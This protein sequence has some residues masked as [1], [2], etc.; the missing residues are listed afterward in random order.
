MKTLNHSPRARRTEATRR[1]QLLAAFDRSGL[2]AAFA[3]QHQ[4]NYTS[5]CGWRARRATAK[6]PPAFV[7]VELT[8]ARAEL[9]EATPIKESCATGLGLDLEQEAQGKKHRLLPQP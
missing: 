6:A 2:S 9:D 1:A 8:P 3:R 5:F 4:L 7:Q